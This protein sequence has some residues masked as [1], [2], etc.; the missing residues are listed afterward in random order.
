MRPYAI[1]EA[2]SALGLRPGGVELLPEQLLR[3]GLAERL[4]ARH[5]GRIAVPPYSSER[6]AETLTL[7][8][9]AIAGW[10]PQLADRVGEVLYR[11]EFPVI[12]G[13]DCSILLGSM[14]AFRRRGRFGLLFIDGHA[15]FYQ[16][17]A[18][19]K[20]EA[21]SM[22]LAFATGHGPGLLTN[23]ENRRPLVRSE[24]VVAFAFRDW[25][26]QA[27]YG[28]QPLPPDLLAIDLKEVRRTGIEAS[29]ERAVA[30]VTRDEL[31]GFFIHLDADCLDD[32]VMPAVDYRNPD[33]LSWE[34]LRTV[35]R[36]A[37]GSGRAMGIEVAIYNPNLDPEGLAGRGLVD[38]LAESLGTGAPL[39]AARR[40]DQP[41]VP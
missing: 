17:E 29:S 34:E 19:P 30:H 26:D 15:D 39:E 24:D 32:A 31:D 8:A 14:L 22:E 40:Q 20:G 10:S 35:L 1:I 3:F 16:P 25:E 28:S 5:A 9:H 37:L 38:V 27:E 4:Q 2:P 21:A 36:R 33:G 23:L 12:L 13:G 18:E 7:N 41:A 11:E 6:D